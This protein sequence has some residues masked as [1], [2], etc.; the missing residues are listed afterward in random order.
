MGWSVSLGYCWGG[1]YS[2]LDNRWTVVIFVFKLEQS[3]YLFSL[4]N[5]RPCRD[6]IPGPPRYQ[7]DMLP[8]ELSWLGCTFI[9]YVY[10][11]LIFFSANV[12]LLRFGLTSNRKQ[13]LTIIVKSLHFSLFSQIHVLWS[14][15]E[16]QTAIKAGFNNN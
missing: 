15:C 16:Y 12:C 1:G 4:K 2:I 6:S 13:S 10:N 5:Y 7:A 11:M 14:I 9:L 8:I 3:S